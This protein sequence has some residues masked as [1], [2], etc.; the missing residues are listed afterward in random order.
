M[1]LIAHPL[2]IQMF[3]ADECILIEHFVELAQLEEDEFVEVLALDMPVLP[4]GFCEPLYGLGWD[5]ERRG[6]VVWV[7][8]PAASRISAT[9]RSRPI[10]SHFNEFLWGLFVVIGGF[11]SSSQSSR[12]LEFF[13]LHLFSA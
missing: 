3:I 5:H 13:L 8:G 4:H 2:E 11:V 12:F 9:L 6:I 10:R 1:H 7:V